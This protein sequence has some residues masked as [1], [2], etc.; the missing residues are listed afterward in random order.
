MLLGIDVGGTFIKYGIV[1]PDGTI[2]E[3]YQTPTHAEE[4][5]DAMVGRIIRIAKELSL[6]A[7]GK[8]IGIGV[9]GVV[10]PRTKHVQSPPNLPGWV[11]VPLQQMVA[12]ATG[13]DV[14]VEN[15]ANAGAI[16]EARAGAGKELRDFLYVTLGTGVGGGIIFN[17]H[18]HTGPHGDAGEV[19][20]IYMRSSMSDDEPS[21]VL[22]HLIGRVG[23]LKRYGGGSDVD[24]ADID[25]RASLGDQHAMDVM[26][27]TGKLL[28][29]GL[30]GM[31]AVLGLRTV[32]IGG[33]I[34]RSKIILDV[35]RET[36]V[37]RAIPTIAK[38]GQ[39][40]SAHFLNDAGLVGA[41]ML[42]MPA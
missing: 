18:L 34:S 35:A 39:I 2:V 14:V 17:K 19:G 27:E 29:I 23:I 41:G 1:E 3:Q 6:K 9:P 28:G 25:T 20:H 42:T 12:D 16:A 30:C 40:L 31:T 21:Y 15:D 7:P 26:V 4:G 22:E 10:D 37:K 33:G 32:I 11:S 8:P 36:L 24:V 5:R 13:V 38:N